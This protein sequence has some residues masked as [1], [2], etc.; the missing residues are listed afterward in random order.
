MC[1]PGTSLTSYFYRQ[2]SITIL[3]SFVLEILNFL[4][5]KRA[6]FQNT[7]DLAGKMPV[8]QHFYMSL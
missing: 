5:K 4:I 7:Y 3:Y 1:K 2:T 6:F 8:F